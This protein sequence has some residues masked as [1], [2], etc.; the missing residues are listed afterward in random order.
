MGEVHG[1]SMHHHMLPS[2]QRSWQHRE[3]WPA[4]ARK[5][6]IKQPWWICNGNSAVE[7]CRSRLRSSWRVHVCDNGSAAARSWC[8]QSCVGS[9]L[10][11]RSRRL[12]LIPTAKLSL[13]L[14][15]VKSSYCHI[16]CPLYGGME[17]GCWHGLDASTGNREAQ[18]SRAV[19]EKRQDVDTQGMGECMAHSAWMTVKAYGPYPY[20]WAMGLIYALCPLVAA[21]F[22]GTLVALRLQSSMFWQG[23]LWHMLPKAV[24]SWD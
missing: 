6:A 24:G 23:R 12:V 9:V 17:W 10:T 18:G 22:R 13:R 5:D 16:P 1:S 15:F 8:R 3:S 19:C 4:V 11:A 2:V 14:C 7:S 21:S 20:A